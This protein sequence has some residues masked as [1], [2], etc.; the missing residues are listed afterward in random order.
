MFR[1]I[2]LC[3]LILVSLCWWIP[4]SAQLCTGSLGDPVVNITFGS[5]TNPGKPISSTL[6]SY[7]FQGSDCPGDGYYTILNR[8]L[9]CFG[10]T[11]HNLA[12]DHTGD[13]NGYFM[14]VN[15]SFQPSDFYIERVD[16]LCS[17]TTFEFSAW[18]MNMMKPVNSI[19]PDITFRIE[20]LNGEVLKS[21]NTGELPVNANPEWK[22]YGFYFTTPPGVSSVV[23][24]MR[25]NAPGGYGNDLCLDDI[26]FRPCG[27]KLEASIGSSG[28]TERSF[29]EGI[30]SSLTLSSKISEGYN[31]PAFQWQRNLDDAGWIDLAG[32]RGGTLD[33]SVRDK[34]KYQYRVM[35]AEESNM[36]ILNCR[37]ASNPVTL[38]VHENPGIVMESQDEVCEGSPLQI[39]ASVDFKSYTQWTVTW[40]QPSGTISSSSPVPNGNNGTIDFVIDRSRLTDEGNYLLTASNETGC[41]SKATIAMKV[42]P[43]PKVN[44]T[45]SPLWCTGNEATLNANTSIPAPATITAW[46]WNLDNGQQSDLP[47]VKTTYTTGQYSPTVFVTASNGCM[48]D[49]VKNVITVHPKPKVNFGLPEVC[50]S[51]P[52]A[53]FTD[54]SSIID[55]SETYFQYRWTFNDPAATPGNPDVSS[56]QHP[57]HRYSSTGIYPVR[58]E[59]TSGAG[60][61]SDTT[62]PFTVNGSVP[63][64]G[65]DLDN[66]LL[67]CSDAPVKILD[68]SSVDFGSITRVEVFW[69]YANDPLATTKDEEPFM[70]KSFTHVYGNNINI[71]GQDLRIRYVAYS[72]INCV[73]ETEQRI[74]V[75]K[76]PE[77]IFNALNPVCEE[78][79]AFSV[80]SARETMGVAGTGVF[81]GPGISSTG[82]FTP[83]VAGEGSH[84]LAYRFISDKGC[85]D[86]AWQ[87]IV[88][89][90]QPLV[91]AG[92]DRTLIIG[93]VITLEARATG[94]GLKY[95]WSP[96]ERIND[97]LQLQP[98]VS[99]I[100]ETQYRL[101]VES[102][103]GCKNS[104]EVMVKV[105]EYLVI[106]N[107]FTPN[108]DGK[109]DTWK[110]PYLGSYPDF[111]VKVF[112]RYGQ[113][114]Y[115][116]QKGMVNWD[117]RVNGKE[118]PTGT[119]VYV[120]DRKSFG[121]PVKGSFQ[122]IR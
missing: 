89:Y 32:E 50:L 91:N 48:S 19:K 122:L 58:L 76:S 45:A 56:L 43:K 36:S 52:F 37:V 8:T 67:L 118:A 33:V 49:T 51:D 40:M 44:I 13:K 121:E 66:S 74:V 46:S 96:E 12:Q 27:A 15:A 101:D 93:G 57:R 21:Y 108:N 81:T 41:F 117:G 68:R 80:N 55:N 85:A 29:C 53:Q 87:N 59:V 60:C 4:L 97:P 112:N 65:F 71:D 105:F 95:R 30:S 100:K 11:W 17:N 9:D 28:E 111:E 120:L 6:T 1:H 119:Y 5:G 23:I 83:S 24:R 3:C 86:T 62:I 20:K 82:L 116:S 70:G 63:K 25:N 10:S 99:P 104:D 2:K 75:F 7:T 31:N 26:Q 42:L 38:L 106:P 47:T 107:A 64:A 78:V 79:E 35:V 110:I 61:N 113:L 102:A 54:S 73:S 18:L 84:E 34:G 22:Q 77:V 103:M 16:G 88:V 39:N 90:P 98:L 14:L 94:E 92:P 109:N 69:D 115:R 114:V 72:G